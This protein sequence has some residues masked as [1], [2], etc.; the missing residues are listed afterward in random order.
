MLISKSFNFRILFVLLAILAVSEKSLSQKASKKVL[1]IN[2]YHIGYQ[3]TDSITS[4]IISVFNKT[5]KVELYVEYLDGKRYEDSTYFKRLLQVY[6]LKYKKGMF[7]LVILSDNLALEFSL[8]YGNSL[9][10]DIPVVFCGV[11]NPDLYNLS[12]VPYWGITETEEDEASLRQM[13]EML[14]EMKNIYF[15]SDKKIRTILYSDFTKRLSWLV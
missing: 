7:D 8:T 4:A 3:W 15:I 13:I 11:T 10:G 14:P 9:F 2:S 12:D 1:L 6:E 5:D